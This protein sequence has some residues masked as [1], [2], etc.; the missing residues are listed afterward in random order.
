M[1]HRLKQRGAAEEDR[2]ASEASGSD[3]SAVFVLGGGAQSGSVMEQQ[4][5]VSVETSVFPPR[6]DAASS[7]AGRGWAEPWKRAAGSVIS[8]ALQARLCS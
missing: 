5:D 3:G 2:C 4:V 1:I 6:A 8:A 7:C